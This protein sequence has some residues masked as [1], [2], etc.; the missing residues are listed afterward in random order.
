MSWFG[1]ARSSTADAT[2][3]DGWEIRFKP[4][5]VR[6]IMDLE[7]LLY[8]HGKKDT[9]ERFLILSVVVG[10]VLLGAGTL[11]SISASQGSAAAVT[12]IGSFITFVSTVVLVFYWLVVGSK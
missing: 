4:W 3:N 12:L 11:G 7:K 1:P 5:V 9:V 2:R 8:G 10:A 6:E